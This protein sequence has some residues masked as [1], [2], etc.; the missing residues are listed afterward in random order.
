LS[1]SQDFFLQQIYRHLKRLN[2][3]PDLERFLIDPIPTD[4]F[5]NK[6]PFYLRKSFRWTAGYANK[7]NYAKELLH[8]CNQSGI[9]TW[10]NV[11]N[12]L[13]IWDIKKIAEGVYSDVF[14]GEYKRTMAILKLIP[15]GAEGQIERLYENSFREAAAKVVVLKELTGLSEVGE[16]HSTEGFIQLNGAMVIKGNYPLS[17]VHAWKVYKQSMSSYKLNPTFFP[18][19]QNYLLLA[20][21]YSEITLKDYKIVNIRQAYSIIYQLFMA[22]AAAE[23]RLSYEHRRLSVK[24]VLIIS[25]DPND[26]IRAYFD[27]SEVYIHTHGVKVKII[28]S[29]FCR[30]TKDESLI[31]FDWAS[32]EGFLMGE[33]NLEQIAFQTMRT[34]NKNLWQPFCPTSNVIWLTYIIDYV[35]DRLLQLRVD[36]PEIRDEFLDHFK[37]LHLYDT[38]WKWISDHIDSYMK[39]EIIEKSEAEEA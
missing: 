19:N 8:I 21:E 34:L 17:M 33:N 14:I 39:K 9:K 16:G 7:R 36:S 15:I 22:T 2:E 13:G 11:R 25:C 30:M 5:K 23:F 3:D 31:Y 29:S 26:T 20:F 1:F 18:P 35:H 27:G 10:K 37:F 28:S 4:Y 24:N 38:A 12:V 32:N 6:R